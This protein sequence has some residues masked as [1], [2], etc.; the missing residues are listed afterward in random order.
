MV[1]HHRAPKHRQHERLQYLHA[2]VRGADSRRYAH[3]AEVA[4]VGM[5]GNVSL[6]LAG[7]TLDPPCLGVT[8]ATDWAFIG[9]RR[10]ELLRERFI[11]TTP[12]PMTAMKSTP[13]TT[14]VPIMSIEDE[15]PAAGA[16]PPA[17][18]SAAAL[19][20]PSLPV[21]PMP[22]SPVFTLLAVLAATTW[23]ERLAA[24]TPVKPSAASAASRSP[25][26]TALL[27][28]VTSFSSAPSA[29]KVT[30]TVPALLVAMERTVTGVP[31]SSELRAEV[32]LAW[33]SIAASAE[34]PLTSARRSAKS[35]ALGTLFGFTTPH[36][37][38]P[39]GHVVPLA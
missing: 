35:P 14:R 7:M 20:A 30:I 11:N 39:D 15:E 1:N 21:P 10:D 4:E 25:L 33:F 29:W 22:S 34:M 31:G 32:I 8:G 16:A 5:G 2:T 17:L 6:L 28:A 9:T 13:T 26:F 23:P 3:H 37:T 36:A 24:A 27:K 19:A 38:V 18:S 12:T